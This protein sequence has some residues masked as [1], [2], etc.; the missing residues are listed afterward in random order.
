LRIFDRVFTNWRKWKWLLNCARNASKPTAVASATT[1]K[2][3]NVPKR[4]ASVL[5]N[6]VTS[7]KKARKIEVRYDPEQLSGWTLVLLSKN[8]HSRWA[9]EGAF[10]NMAE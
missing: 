1:T 10:L 7:P 6:H 9:V 2:K 5:L 4:L 3:V 8:A